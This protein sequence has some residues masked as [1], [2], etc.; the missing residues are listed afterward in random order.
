MALIT[1]SD[2]YQLG[3][4]EIDAQHQKLVAMINTLHDA[5]KEGRGK[6]VIQPILNELL[7]YTK[8]HFAREEELFA[9]HGYP[10]RDNHGRIHKSLTQQVI[11]LKAKVDA[12]SGVLAVQ[13]M[14]FM[15]DW[16]TAHIL[17]EDKKYAPFLK[18][19][20]VQ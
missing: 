16:L 14:A 7:A 1:W 3:I 19:K 11:D 9:K 2:E 20:G 18:S 8:T 12:G 5:M 10:T 15:K 4:K 6:D 13:V 17:A